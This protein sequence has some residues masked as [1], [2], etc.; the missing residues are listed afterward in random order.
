[1]SPRERER[2]RDIAGAGAA[3]DHRRPAVD[4]RVEAAPSCVVPGVGGADAGA[5]QRAPQLIQAL[6]EKRIAHTASIANRWYLLS[7]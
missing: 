7:G 2:G 3:H 1:M 6:V 5:G 4:Q